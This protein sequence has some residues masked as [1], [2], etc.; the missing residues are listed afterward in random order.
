MPSSQNVNN[1]LNTI[2][3][4]FRRCNGAVGVELSCSWGQWRRIQS[5]ERRVC[6]LQ[7]IRNNLPPGSTQS[8]SKLIQGFSIVYI[9]NQFIEYEHNDNVHSYPTH[10]RGI[11][12]LV[13]ENT[14]CIL[15][16]NFFNKSLL[17]KLTFR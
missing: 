2:L 9:N 15:M 5:I 12:A 17:N 7:I 1:I 13:Q 8:A 11:G 4:H 14:N 10:L 16:N 6:V 3:I